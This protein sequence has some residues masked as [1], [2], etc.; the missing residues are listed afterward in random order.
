M[1]RK[2]F[3]ERTWDNSRISGNTD[4]AASE[5]GLEEED[6]AQIMLQTV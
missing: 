5:N 3:S 2:E 1:S 4:D 6:K